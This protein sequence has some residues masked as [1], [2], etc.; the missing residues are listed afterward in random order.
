VHSPARAG[1]MSYATRLKVSSTPTFAIRW[2][3]VIAFADTNEQLYNKYCSN[4]H[5]LTSSRGSTTHEHTNTQTHKHT[6]TYAYTCDKFI[7]IDRYY[8]CV[9]VSIYVLCS[10]VLPVY[11]ECLCQCHLFVRRQND[12]FFKRLRGPPVLNLI[13]YIH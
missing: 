9:Y 1:S 4:K 12:A 3:A 11:R 10:L 2:M 5:R 6:D 13:T 8:M 7:Q